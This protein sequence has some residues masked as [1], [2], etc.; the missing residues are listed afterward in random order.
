MLYDPIHF[1]V[2]MVIVLLIPLLLYTA[3]VLH[4]LYLMLGEAYIDV[5]YF[6]VVHFN[7]GINTSFA[8]T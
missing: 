3:Y 1:A 4:G 5:R 8:V 7:Q 6:C 2:F